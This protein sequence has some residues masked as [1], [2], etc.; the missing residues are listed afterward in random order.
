[1]FLKYISYNDAHSSPS[2]D[3]LSESFIANDNVIL[4]F[5]V[6]Y[7]CM[8][9]TFALDRINAFISY[10][11]IPTLRVHIY[12]LNIILSLYIYKAVYYNSHIVP[13]DKKAIFSRIFFHGIGQHSG[14]PCCTSPYVIR[15]KEKKKS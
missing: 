10:F 3:C 7:V 5:N 4:C 9:F 13:T 12:F 8:N 11:S 1:M 15:R 6:T 2:K 14:D